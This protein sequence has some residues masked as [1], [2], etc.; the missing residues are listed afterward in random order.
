MLEFNPYPIMYE[1]TPLLHVNS[2]TN[3]SDYQ[4]TVNLP[5]GQTEVKMMYL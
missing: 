1:Y 3:S 4:K 5:C 2:S